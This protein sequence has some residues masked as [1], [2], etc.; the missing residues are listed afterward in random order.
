MEIAKPKPMD[1][2]AK[3]GDKL[4]PW[5]P[6]FKRV[7]QTISYRTCMLS[8]SMWEQEDRSIED[9]V[10]CTWAQKN[11]NI[12]NKNSLESGT[13]NLEEAANT[14][15]G[16]DLSS[17]WQVFGYMLKGLKGLEQFGP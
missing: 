9:V 8:G 17:T 5:T 7:G 10:W 15:K 4:S 13:A 16:F 3:L 2:I 11:P 12:A 14:V 6:E 1:N